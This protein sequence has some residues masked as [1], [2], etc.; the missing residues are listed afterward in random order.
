MIYV[1]GLDF[2]RSTN[3]GASYSDA[4]GGMHVDHHGL[5]FGPGANPV[6]YN[7]NDGGVYRST[8]GGSVWTKLYDLPITQ[9][10]RVALDA[11]NPGALY[12]G[13][14]DNSTVRTLTGATDDWTWI[15]G[16]DGFMPVIHPTNS[17]RIWAQYQYGNLY[18]SDDGGYGWV[19]AMGGIGGSDRKNWN[20]PLLQGPTDIDRRYFGTNRVYRSTGNTTWTVISPDLTGGP[21]ENNPGQVRG[22]LTALAVSPLDADVI[23]A[24]SDDGYVHVTTDGG[25]GWT[26]VSAG[27]PERW[28][29]SV[30][31]DPFVREA[32]YVTISGFRWAEPLPHVFRT[33]DLGSTWVAI[34][35]NLPEAPANDLIADPVYSGRY[36]VATDVGV[37]QTVDG[38]GSWS[39]LGADLPNVVVN[40]LAFREADRVLIAGTYGRSFFGYSVGDVSAVQEPVP[41]LPL[42]VGRTFRPH[43]NPTK[44]ATR[45]SWVTAKAAPVA[46]DV[47]TVSGRHVWSRTLGATT[48]GPGSIVWKGRDSRGEALPPGTYFVRV[49]EGEKVIGS[50]TVVFL[51]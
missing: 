50:E 27:L 51:P 2:Y 29:T 42:T 6:I 15:L 48:A 13:T 20:S 9:V 18:Y 7:G 46:V 14:Q 36:F 10:Y 45:I 4:S 17:D 23:W 41:E 25:S 37:Y 47:Y 39:M 44:D 8:N 49:R 31:T 30:R 1:L 28:V 40:S 19:S 43:P 16:G 3:G 32:A 11:S 35:G 26:D 24:G 21:H 38:G 5:D 12:G 33:A 34:A 22:T